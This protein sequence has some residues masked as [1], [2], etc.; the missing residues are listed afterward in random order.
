MACILLEVHFTA[1]VVVKGLKK[2]LEQHNESRKYVQ[3]EL[4]SVCN[5]FNAVQTS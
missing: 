1:D 3:G 2:R 4:A 5:R